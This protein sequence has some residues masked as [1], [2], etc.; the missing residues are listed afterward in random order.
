MKN[1]NY[2]SGFKAKVIGCAVLLGVLSATGAGAQEGTLPERTRAGEPVKSRAEIAADDLV[3]LSADKIIALL[4]TESGLLLQVKKALVRKAYEQG[5]LLD[6]QDLTDDAVF[7]LIREDE[8]VRVL[9]TREI[10]DRYY[11]RAKPTREEL[12]RGLVSE[13]LRGQPNKAG[14]PVDQ[15]K[16]APTQEEAYWSG[17]EGREERYP[18]QYQN[19]Q[20]SERTPSAQPS[21]N[22]PQQ[23]R[24]QNP[25]SPNPDE[26]GPVEP[27]VGDRR[28]QLERTEAPLQ[29]GDYPESLQAGSSAMP[30]ITPED[31]PQL[32]ST[33]NSPQ[34]MSNQDRSMG[35][36]ST[37]SFSGTGAG[38]ST[39]STQW[40]D[41]SSN[42]RDQYFDENRGEM[43]PQWMNRQSRPL[44]QRPQQPALR[45]TP[46][47]YA[48]VPSL[49]DL[50]SQYS[51][52]P[53][54]L[55]RFG[56]EIF[57]NG[58]GN[59]ERLPMDM[60]V[61][62]E[63]VLGPGDGLSIQLW[64]GVSE[65]LVR[66]VD[67]QGR[68]A[69][70]ET[71]SLEVSG[72]SL[73]EVQHLIQTA[74]RSEFRDV[75][76]DVSLSRLRSVRIFV[77]G[78]VERS[79]AYDV[80]SLSTPLNAVFMAGGPTSAGSLR[81]I[82][83]LRG[84]QLL[85]T[86]DVYDLLLHGVR[87]DL[88]GLQS[89]D[90]V[91]VPPLG[92][93]VTV[94]GMVRRPA[95]YELDGE[96]NLAQI[97]ELAGGV[98]QSGTL[99]HVDVERTEAHQ[100]RSMLRL[101]IPE[102]NNKETVTKALDDFQIQDGDKVKISPILPY[103][104]KTVYLEGHVF[105]PGKFA[106]RDGMKVT[107]I[108]HSYNELLPEPYK[109][110]AEIIRLNPPD[111]TPQVLAFN[112]EDALAGKDQDLVL[113]PFDTVR[114]F[115][116]FDFE[117]SPVVTVTGEVRDPGDHITN[118]ATYL[119][120]AV[121]LAGG[122]T[123]DAQLSD[124][125]VFRKTEDGKLKVL[126]VDLTKALAGDPKDNLLLEPSDR[127]FIHKDLARS[128]PPTVLAEGEVAR[129]GKYPL[130]DNMTAAELVRLA[131]G[132][133]RSAYTEEADLTRY[134]VEHGTQMLSEHIPVPIAKALADEPDA[135]VRLH[136]GDVL[137]IRQVAGWNDLRATIA[138]K[139]EVVHPGTY[140]IQEGERLSSIIARAGGFRTDA[141]P[142]GAI[143]QR[144]QV[145]ELEERNR[146][147]LISEI[148]DQGASLRQAPDTDPDQKAA[149]DAALQQWQTTLD[150][151]RNTPPA[152]RLV[153]HISANTRRW[154]NSSSDIQVRSGDSIYIPKRPNTVV[155]DGSVYNA[156]A[157]TF[158]PGKDAGWY[159]HQAGGPT[160]MANK[161]A[162]FVI[163]A[164]GSVVGGS[165][166]LFTG[167]VERA[168]LQPGDMVMVPEKAFSANS[169][170]KQIL[171]GSQIAYAVGI[172]IQVAKSF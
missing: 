118:G 60:P 74:L 124:A 15:T 133:K 88:Q 75:Q 80:S 168:A 4:R 97:L 19:Q 108:I 161:K 33:S 141:Y 14:T 115:G 5:R 36:S 58:T 98:L 11:V 13:P 147:Q 45:H 57:H 32:L 172:A 131:G 43:M 148:Q 64:G 117:D 10:E 152:G 25:V 162:I 86:T 116:R 106:Y 136:D 49:Y 167:G 79:G 158:K 84:T 107:D 71:G 1:T 94:E 135:D 144:A 44:P 171:E 143:F 91:R 156:T 27:G 66:V 99:R 114:V 62:P 154:V 37:G 12:E 78:D 77:V 63:Y 92:A 146:G 134:E 52:R 153:L 96:K 53:A 3:S 90:T 65:R 126:S 6:P 169:R 104:D 123:I 120:D 110:H 51:G 119:R 50:Y 137:T 132:L 34:S 9:I 100:S 42:G 16:P 125:Q 163:R 102:D 7:S 38:P 138:V 127:L 164:D 140:G 145:R 40:P 41:A 39:S 55:Q 59:L 67:R 121:Y 69:L 160:S 46:N 130:G 165:G 20:N 47:P 155:V 18:E 81:I 157:I 56:S 82:E 113:K 30:G 166:G 151:L 73:G 85:Q 129:P 111:Y 24:E 8:N 83:H 89:G 35:Q 150:Q 29:Q 68:V 31:V 2:S 128:D 142:Y 139:G 149:K 21:Y 28:R 72:K 22:V 112:L 103:A 26:Q 159:L 122:A 48:D 170:F 61:G 87:S 95:I 109:R 54:V 70:P 76:A 23:P 93:E 17:H 105:R 101:D